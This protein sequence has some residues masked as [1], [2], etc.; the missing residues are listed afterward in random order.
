M[1][2]NADSFHLWLTIA[3]LMA[4]TEGKLTL[5]PETFERARKLEDER[6]KRI[7]KA[8]AAPTA[9]SNV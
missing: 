1:T 6:V 2:T 8:T 7:S 3:R 9:N 4:M 5:T